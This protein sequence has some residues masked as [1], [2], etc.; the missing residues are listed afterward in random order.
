MVNSK[1]KGSRGERYVVECL[2]KWW[3]SDDFMRS[4]ESGA[5]S[6]QLESFGAPKDITGRLAGDILTPSDFPFCIESKFY[7]EID[8]YSVIR[9]P[10][11]NDLRNWWEQCKNDATKANK[12][13]MLFF[14]EN[15]KKG[16]IGIG[17]EYLSNNLQHEP[18]EIPI[19]ILIAR[20]G[21]DWVVL[22]SWDD[23][24]SY[25]DKEKILQNIKL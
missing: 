19:G 24:S 23:F 13:P 3:G 15:R 2:K 25:F 21:E 10:E 18:H 9:N 11:N 22:M 7:A 20:F 4:P 12:I 1:N 17:V 8:L 6:T 16:Y 5:L 14:R